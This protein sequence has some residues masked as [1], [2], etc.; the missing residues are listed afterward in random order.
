MV[1][2]TLGA[3]VA[4]VMFLA[5]A[6]MFGI[7]YSRMK[8]V[9]AGKAMVVYGRMNPTGRGYVIIPDTGPRPMKFILPI[10]EAFEFLPI[11]ERDIDIDLDNVL[12]DAAGETQKVRLEATA[13]VKIFERPE[14][15]KTAAEHLLG[16]TDD[17]IDWIARRVLEGHICQYLS[18]YRAEDVEADLESAI[19]TIMGHS[20]RDLKN[21]GIEVLS[22][23]IDNFKV[24]P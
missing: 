16:K 8:K 1:D 14:G 20:D 5:M 19:Q 7:F 24:K 6:S 21:I 9:P 12:C 11:G 18:Y 3:I 22:F 23:K 17:D 10:I 15:L 4:A 2:V 13:K